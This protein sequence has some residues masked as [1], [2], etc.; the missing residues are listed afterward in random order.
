MS[1]KTGLRNV[2]GLT[3][4]LA[5]VLMVATPSGFAYSSKEA[6]EKVEA[7]EQAL[8]NA[9]RADE[10]AEKASDDWTKK[11]SQNIRDSQDAE[12]KRKEAEAASV[13]A[14]ETGKEEDIE[15][16]KKAKKIAEAAEKKA[17]ESRKASEAALQTFEK[18]EQDEEAAK[19]QIP[20]LIE[21]AEKA[22]DELPQSS[23]KDK[24]KERIKKVKEGLQ[25]LAFAFPT[26]LDPE[27]VGVSVV[28]TNETIG[29]V[30]TLTLINHSDETFTIRIPPTILASKTG[31]VQNYG[32]TEMVE[33][34]LAPRETKALPLTGV[35]LD[36]RV[37]PAG[38]EDKDEL[39]LLHP[40]TLD[41]N[42]KMQLGGTQAV[43]Q[44]TQ[45]LQR[46]GV[47]KTPY[48]KNPQKEQ[49]TIIQWTTWLFVSTKQGNP[50]KKEDLAKKVYEQVEQA[51]GPLP[52]EKKEELKEGIDDI[53]AAVELTGMKAKLLEP[54][55]EK[56]SDAGK[57]KPSEPMPPKGE[58][59][60][61]KEVP[62]AGTETVPQPVPQTPEIPTTEIPP[63]VPGTGTQQKV[64]GPDV[65]DDYLLRLKVVK[66][67]LL[68][69]KKD[70]EKMG[71]IFES[72]GVA[73]LRKN[74]MRIDYWVYPSDHCPQ[75]C[76]ETLTLAGLCVNQ[77]ATNDIMYGFIGR[78]LDVPLETV[79]AGADVQEVMAQGNVKGKPPYKVAGYSVGWDLARE[80][81]INVDNL[82][83]VMASVLVN[84]Q[85]AVDLM[86]G[87]HQD[88]QLCPEKKGAYR[89]F[90]S[91][92][93]KF[94]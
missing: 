90:S 69:R 52:P 39:A 92:E 93:W 38:P 16:A 26:K 82:M 35:C 6:K 45:E 34:T 18:A 44:T 3:G 40:K 59:E 31:K 9:Q 72:A 86:S 27:K 41:A 8:Q 30:A 81:D 2:V 77:S 28:G 10:R 64:C 55:T 87:P 42:Q 25:Q 33:T 89:D 94:E 57:E 83:R 32:L 78:M 91:E 46:Q 49:D 48:S 58:E 56:I 21:P 43:I 50:V 29:H 11:A 85:R 47:Y 22:V 54:K 19:G 15:A 75:N 60:K 4:V 68:D 17:E 14:Y 53:W 13:K 70:I 1:L 61:P 73:F 76:E 5:F 71:G 63:M 84:N 23:V 62:P 12:K 65:T 24:L 36:A 80:A 37:P 88:C 74:G 79:I 20:P 51:K 7:A 67:R 66:R